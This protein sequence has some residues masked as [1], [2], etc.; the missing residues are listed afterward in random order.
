MSSTTISSGGS[1]SPGASAADRTAT[2]WSSVTVRHFS[3]GSAS[4]KLPRCMGWIRAKSPPPPVQKNVLPDRFSFPFGF[5]LVTVRTLRRFGGRLAVGSARLRSRR[6]C[7]PGATVAD[8]VGRLATG[9]P[10]R[11]GGVGVGPRADPCSRDGSVVVRNIRFQTSRIL[12]G[13]PEL[14]PM[15]AAFL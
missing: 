13:C 6:S 4:T 14:D 11:V 12:A 1:T 3:N 9:A 10:G 15:P 2:P 5:E 7:E 8:D